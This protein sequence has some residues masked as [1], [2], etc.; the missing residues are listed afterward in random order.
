MYT[1][2]VREFVEKAFKVVGL[3]GDEFIE[4]SEKYFR[5]NEVEH[6]L[7]DSSKAQKELNKKSNI[8]VFLVPS[9]TDTKWFHEFV[10][11]KAELRFIKG[12][13]KFGDSKNSA[14]FSSILFTRSYW[15]HESTYK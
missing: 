5:P 1:H 9:R 3:D 13:L 6:L 12:R 11:H 4:I 7:G 8:I 15:P 2:T 10:Y 14:P